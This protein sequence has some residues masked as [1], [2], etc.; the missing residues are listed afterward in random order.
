[1]IANGFRRHPVLAVHVLLVALLLIGL[2]QRTGAAYLHWVALYGC[3][4]TAT[5]TSIFRWKPIKN[6]VAG[7]GELPLRSLFLGTFAITVLLAASHWGTLGHVP[8]IEALRQTDDLRVNAL[9][10]ASNDVPVWI[11][12]AGS[13]V[14][15][16]LVPVALLLAWSGHRKW[17]W[18]MAIVASVYALSLIQKSHTITL[19]V[20]L[21][22][23]FLVSRKWIA[24]GSLSAVFML[25]LGLLVVVGKPEKLQQVSAG[26]GDQAPVLDEGV[27]KRG[28]VG[29]VVWS[30]GRRILFMPGWTVAAWF[31]HVPADIP[32]QQGAAVRPIGAL[33]GKPYRDLSS[34][35]Y[36]LE[37]PELAAQGTQGTM[38]S[39]A[40]MYD[41]ANFGGWGLAF[42]GVVTGALLYVIT[43]LFAGRWRW[44]MA[45][46]TYPLLALT[47]TALPTV[48]L[49]HGWAATLLLFVL[50][51]DRSE[52]ID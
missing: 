19:F 39:A 21:W 13:F 30:L 4:L 51:N 35:V 36:A 34:D 42:A 7:K 49:S 2:V 5:Y 41:Y 46:N 28:L 33:L 52:P 48:L 32:Y 9:R 6:T 43:L 12:Y 18:S 40:F 10:H 20:P 24:F 11:N 23:A 31:E 17:F 14:I 38:G 3:V 22:I 37:Y 50:F 44:A 25:L 26:A 15:K 8:L 29:D 45:L 16:A 47:A 27:A 1:M